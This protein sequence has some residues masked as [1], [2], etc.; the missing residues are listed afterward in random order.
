MA[1]DTNIQ[2]VTA[3]IIEEYVKPR[4]CGD[5]GRKRKVGLVEIRF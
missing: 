4:K 3:T 5:C 2:T 1:N